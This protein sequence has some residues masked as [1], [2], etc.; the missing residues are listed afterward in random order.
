MLQITTKAVYCK[1]FLQSATRAKL[2]ASPSEELNLFELFRGV[3]FII[4]DKLKY[5][6]FV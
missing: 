3:A 1:G 4:V 6:N 2:T 5:T